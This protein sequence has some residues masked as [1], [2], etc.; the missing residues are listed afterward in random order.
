MGQNQPERPKSKSGYQHGVPSRK[1]ILAMIESAGQPQDF[2]E[3]A[4]RLSVATATAKNGL[5]RRLK[6]M[7]KD[8]Q[9]VLNK[10]LQYD[11]TKG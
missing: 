5:K 4:L 7:I 11:T 8:R 10:K 3:L 2:E 1:K 9:L 6:L